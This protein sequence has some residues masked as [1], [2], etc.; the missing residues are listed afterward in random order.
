MDDSLPLLTRKEY[1]AYLR[2][3]R[4]RMRRRRRRRRLRVRVLRALRTTRF[5]LNVL[6]GFVVLLTLTF[7][8]KFAF[9][10]HVP[11]ALRTGPLSHVS[12]YVTWKPWWFGPP[13]FDLDQYL[14]MPDVTVTYSDDRDLLLSNLGRFRAVVEQPNIIWVWYTT[15]GCGPG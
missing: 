4:Q 6:F 8:A 1:Q 9:V 5:W 2:R 10:Y 7:W 11:E 3:R 14:K 12:A 13:V 15:G